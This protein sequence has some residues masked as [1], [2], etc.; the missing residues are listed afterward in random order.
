MLLRPIQIETAVHWFRMSHKVLARFSGHGD[1]I[2]NI[3]PLLKKENVL[4]PCLWGYDY[5]DA[6]L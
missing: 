3:I 6:Y 5:V 2:H 1:S 4:F